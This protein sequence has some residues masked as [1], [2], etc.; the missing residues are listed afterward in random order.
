MR[1]LLLTSTF[2]SAY[3]QSDYFGKLI[4]LG[5]F[6]LS[7][8]SWV[9]MIHKIRL[10]R[11]TKYH[12]FKFE[13]IFGKRKENV[14]NFGLDN[15]TSYLNPYFVIYSSV[16]EK[17]LEVLNK[18][19]FFS[20]CDISEVYL[21]DSD[22]ELI[23]SEV[24]ATISHEAKFLEKNLF[25]L[26]T[27]ITLAPFLG[28]LGTVWGILLTFSNLQSNGLTGANASVLTGLSLALATTVIGLVVAIPALIGYNYL[29]S[30]ISDLTR[31][32]E[33]FSHNLITTLALQYK[34][35]EKK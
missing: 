34:K 9:V 14:L 29:K 5:L 26:S 23:A 28:L 8:C 11:K 4:F 18:N 35:V 15:F 6:T 19:S 16:K 24:D 1:D 30:Y 3:S 25:V 20:K 31:E 2:L 7:I 10:T 12:C 17:T 32:M 22:L 27:V 21:T 13:N 33:H